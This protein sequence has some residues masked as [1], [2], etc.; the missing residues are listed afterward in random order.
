MVTARCIVSLAVHNCWPLYQVDVNNAFM[1]SD[2]NEDVYMDLPP[3][4]YDEF[5]T[6]VCKLVKSL[7]GL[8]QALRQW[9]EKLTSA[10]NE[11]GFRQSINDYSLFVKNKN[12]VLLAL[13][14][15]VDDIVIT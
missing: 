13:L 9:N 12:N 5:E 1:Y 8:K 4:Y 6:K 7:Y 2:L 15:Y 3:R 14:V 11:N 10:L